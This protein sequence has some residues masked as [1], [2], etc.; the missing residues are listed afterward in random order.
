MCACCRWAETPDRPDCRDLTLEI[1]R[2]SSAETRRAVYDGCS[3]VEYMILYHG[4]RPFEPWR[5]QLISDLLAAGAP[6]QPQYRARVLPIAAAH[7]ARREAELAAC[8][9]MAHD[10]RAHETFVGLS[11]DVRELREAERAVEERRARVA[12]LEL[13][14]CAL[15]AAG[16]DE[17]E[18]D[19]SNESE[20]DRSG[21]SGD[22]SEEESE[23]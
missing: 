5:A 19:E 4:A 20:S 9:S 2:L 22:D 1:F 12:A 3:A 15:G 14:L 13:E 8:Q 7:A 6:V 16:S 10:W 11:L 17:S 21:S 18:S 23:G